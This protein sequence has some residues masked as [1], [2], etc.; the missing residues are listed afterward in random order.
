MPANIN[1]GNLYNL[2]AEANRRAGRTGYHS[3][4]SSDQI[5]DMITFIEQG[6]S[7]TQASTMAS[8]GVKPQ[9]QTV[10]PAVKPPTIMEQTEGFKH[11]PPPVEQATSTPFIDVNADPYAGGEEQPYTASSIDEIIQPAPTIIE[12]EPAYDPMNTGA[13]AEEI[14]TLLQ[15]R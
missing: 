14:Q 8:R 9:V 5:K 15:T 7:P 1:Y 11:T 6:V 12:Q 4:T 10:M 13:T 3:G 2:L